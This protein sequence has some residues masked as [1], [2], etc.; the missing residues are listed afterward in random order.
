MRP[1]CRIDCTPENVEHTLVNALAAKSAKALVKALRT[2]MAQI[3][4]AANA[5]VRQVLRKVGTDAGDAPQVTERVC[6]YDNGV[7]GSIR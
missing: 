3:R 7:H 2:T 5:Q 1:G 6:A 4:N